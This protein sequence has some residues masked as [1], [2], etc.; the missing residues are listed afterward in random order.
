MSSG[1][2]ELRRDDAWRTGLSPRDRRVT[3]ALTA[4]LAIPY[5]YGP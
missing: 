3:M 2:V 1:L 5:G 4:P